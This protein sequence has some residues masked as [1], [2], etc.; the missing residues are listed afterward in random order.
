MQIISLKSELELPSAP[1]TK[2]LAG[3][4]EYSFKFETQTSMLGGAL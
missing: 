1:G 2:L 3:E 4:P